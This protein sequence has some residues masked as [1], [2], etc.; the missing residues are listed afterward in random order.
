[1]S[2]FKKIGVIFTVILII[3]LCIVCYDSKR[4]KVEDKE[5][6]KK[7]Q[8]WIHD[9]EQLRTILEGNIGMDYRLSNDKRNKKIDS[10][11]NDIKKD[12]ISDIKMY[13][14][15]SELFSDIEVGHLTFQPA[16]IESTNLSI[17]KDGRVKDAMIYPIGGMWFGDEFRIV[18]VLSVNEE[19]A[20][21]VLEKIN[22]IPFN[23]ILKKYDKIII[24]ETNGGIKN[25]FQRYN[26]NFFLKEYMDY[27]KITK[28]TNAIFTIKKDG[29]YVDVELEPIRVSELDSF[30][31]VHTL[32]D[33]EAA[34]QPMW[35]RT[36]HNS[37]NAPFTYVH[38]YDNYTIYFQYNSCV[39]NTS[40]HLSSYRED[41][42]NFQEFFD[43]MIW[44]MQQ[45]QG[46]YSQFIIDLRHN[47]GGDY[48]L[49]SDAI[50]R[51]MAF[52]QTQNIKV[53]IG[54][55][56]SAGHMAVEDILRI[57]PNIKIYG[58][59]SSSAI[60]NY[61]EITNSRFVLDNCKW[62]VQLPMK[63]DFRDNLKNRQKEWDKGIIPDYYVSQTYD[64]FLTGIDTVYY[65]TIL[66]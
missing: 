61:T 26:Y 11:I 21:G 48:Y 5:L 24:N 7:Q 45:N 56:Y 43:N 25:V 49:I 64:D 37:N 55:N 51:H 30:N 13:H 36:L 46:T 53:I 65:Y 17:D 22:G 27:L 28:K 34:M 15:I 23:K 39:D 66:N 2:K 9:M 19:V 57:S 8:Q 1:M 4:L 47:L 20:G 54:D 62:K 14:K 32:S 10:I 40:R 16:N 18:N 6:S 42:P 59:E 60:K 35:Y 41:L 31:Y 29:K 52:L 50:D 33:I 12:D 58:E 3:F 63:E 44:Y 38:D